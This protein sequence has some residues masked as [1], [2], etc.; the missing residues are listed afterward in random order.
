MCNCPVIMSLRSE[1]ISRWNLKGIEKSVLSLHGVD[2]S[3]YA[4]ITRSNV[5]LGMDKPQSLIRSS[6]DQ[7]ASRP[8]AMS[9]CNSCA[10]HCMPSELSSWTALP[11]HNIRQR[12]WCN[13]TITKCC[14]CRIS[15]KR[16]TT[17]RNARQ[18]CFWLSLY[19]RPRWDPSASRGQTMLC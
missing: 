7:G 2:N 10:Q 1:S 15:T 18:L 3:N 14:T 5:N 11:P 6:S 13:W 16:V 4:K 9:G 19:P 8:Q 17:L 12:Q